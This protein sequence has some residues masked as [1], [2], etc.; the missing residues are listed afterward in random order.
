[1]VETN[2]KFVPT[3]R[4]NQIL[5]SLEDDFWISYNANTAN[6][7]SEMLSSLA[8]MYS[9]TDMENKEETCL[10]IMGTRLILIGDWREQYLAIWPDRI[11]AMEIYD[12]NKELH[13]SNWSEDDV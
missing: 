7:I 11:K 2:Y 9:G 12:K 4:G 3:G 1:M 8:S 6:P 10:A 5:K 13:R